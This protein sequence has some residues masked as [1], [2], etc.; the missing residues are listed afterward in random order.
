VLLDHAARHDRASALA[1][2]GQELAAG[3]TIAARTP[4]RVI[5]APTLRNKI[6]TPS[7]QST[8]FEHDRIAAIAYDRDHSQHLRARHIFFVQL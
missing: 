3:S 2:K 1:Q 8:Q 4:T 6:E 5:A 7:S